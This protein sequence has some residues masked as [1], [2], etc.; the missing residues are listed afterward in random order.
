[1]HTRL[2]AGMIAAFAV[3]SAVVSAEQQ[4]QHFEVPPKEFCQGRRT[5]EPVRGTLTQ[6]G[7][8]R[9]ETPGRMRLCYGGAAKAG[10]S[11]VWYADF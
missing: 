3:S 8:K 6:R 2:V 7:S 5:G 4:R 11:D 9:S 1:M 10:V